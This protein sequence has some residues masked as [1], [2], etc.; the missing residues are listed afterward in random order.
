MTDAEIAEIG[1]VDVV[2]G[3]VPATWDREALEGAVARISAG[4]LSARSVL[5]HPPYAPAD[6]TPLQTSREWRLITSQQLAQN[7]ANIVDSLKESFRGIAEISRKLG[8]RACGLIAS[9]LSSVRAEWV[10]LLLAPVVEDDFD[11]VTPC[12]ARHAFEGMINR[13]LVYPFFRALYGKKLR[14]PLGPDLGISRRLLDR[15]DAGARP[16]LHPFASLGPEA[17]S[18]GMKICQ[19]HLGHRTYSPPDS[20]ALSSLLSQVLGPVFLDTERY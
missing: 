19:A 13:A 1:Q 15:V 18:N 5:V 6:A 12:Y 10:Q 8:A 17:A 2:V 16:G 11:L 14:N 9:D 7:P 4:A 20:T 3:L